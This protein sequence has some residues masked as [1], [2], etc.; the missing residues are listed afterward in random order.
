MREGY[1][2]ILSNKNNDVLYVGVTSDIVKRIWEHKNKVTDGFTSRYNVTKLVYY[3]CYNDIETAIVREKQ[4]KGGSRKKKID[5]V[6]SVNKDWI[7]LYPD[8]IK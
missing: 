8:I 1:V 3:E 7:D 4:I 5:L 6:E 2:Y